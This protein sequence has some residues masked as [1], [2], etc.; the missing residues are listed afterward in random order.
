LSREFLVWVAVANLLAWPVAFLIMNNW[1]RNFA[2]QAGFGW[3]L[4]VAVGAGSLAAAFATVGYQ[5][6][7]AA[8]ANPVKALKYE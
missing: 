8:R 2:S 4:Y 6:L 7:R 3:W 5:T 1:L